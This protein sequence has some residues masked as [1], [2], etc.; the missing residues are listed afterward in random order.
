MPLIPDSLEGFDVSVRV[1]LEPEGLATQIQEEKRSR[2]IQ[3]LTVSSG[4]FFPTVESVSSS[5]GL[6]VRLIRTSITREQ[7][8]TNRKL[9]GYP[10]CSFA[11][12]HKPRWE[13]LE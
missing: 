13:R 6:E 3:E 2:D 9:L 8:S 11:G 1:S 12:T 10:L 4:Y 5:M 7:G